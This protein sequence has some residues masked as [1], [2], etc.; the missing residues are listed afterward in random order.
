MGKLDTIKEFAHELDMCYTTSIKFILEELSERHGVRDLKLSLSR[1]NRLCGYKRGWGPILEIVVDALNAVF[2]KLGYI[3]KEIEGK[4]NLAFLRDKLISENASF[5]LV[6][7]GPKYIADLKGEDKKYNVIGYPE[8]D[9]V[10]VV[11]GFNNEIKFIDPMEKI[12]LKSSKID[13]VP[14]CLS[15]SLFIHY[16]GNA[17]PP[18]WIMWI[19]KVV[20]VERGPLDE[21]IRGGLK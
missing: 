15:K 3:A 21:Y 20:E 11:T 2:D 16:W 7:F 18:Y 6:S 4:E 8:W 14:N 5:P 12:L 17:D 1:I 19:E 9:H 13:K 10:V